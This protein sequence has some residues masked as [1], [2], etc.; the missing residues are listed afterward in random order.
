[1]S[2]IIQDLNRE[3]AEK[4]AVEY[5][6]HPAFSGQNPYIASGPSHEILICLMPDGTY[7]VELLD[8]KQMEDSLQQTIKAYKEYTEAGKS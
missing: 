7:L 5:Q 4:L 6:T 8:K 3:Q 1:M 2:L